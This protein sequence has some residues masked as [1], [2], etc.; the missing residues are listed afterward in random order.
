MLVTQ[1][2]YEPKL[3]GQNSE[4]MAKVAEAESVF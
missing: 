2:N 4:N 1:N 3:V